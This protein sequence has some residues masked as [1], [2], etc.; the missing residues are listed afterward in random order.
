[1]NPLFA[2]MLF[3]NSGDVDPD[4][5]TQEL[6]G[7][8]DFYLPNVVCFLD[9]CVLVKAGLVSDGGEYRLGSLDMNCHSLLTRDDV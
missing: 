5:L 4:S 2:F 9:G 8:P 7:L 6:A 3:A 1:M